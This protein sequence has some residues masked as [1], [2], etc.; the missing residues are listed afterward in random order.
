[1]SQYVYPPDLYPLV[2]DK[3]TQERSNSTVEL[4]KEELFKE[5]VETTYHTSFFTEEKRHLWFRIIFTNK[6]NQTDAEVVA[7]IYQFVF[8][9]KPRPFNVSE[10]MRLSPAT[11]PTHVLIA[12]RE[13]DTHTLEIWGL[14]VSD[15]SWWDFTR[16]ETD[17]GHNPPDGLLISSN[18]AGSISLSRSGEPLISLNQGKIQLGPNI[19]WESPLVDFFIEGRK[20]L[21]REVCNE[22]NRQKFAEDY[23]D[24]YPSNFYLWFLER[25]LNRIREKGHGGTLLIVP[26][27]VTVYDTRLNDR[28]S[29]KYTCSYDAFSPLVRLLV[30]QTNYF[31]AFFSLNKREQI[32]KA[33]FS[34]YDLLQE[35]YKQAEDNVRQAVSFLSS[36]SAVDGAIVM[37]DKLRLIGFGAE[38][39]AT[40]P[41]LTKINMISNYGNMNKHEYRN[42]DLFGTRHRSAFRFC[43]SFED[44]IAAIVSSDGDIRVA[45]RVG[46]DLNLWSNVSVLLYPF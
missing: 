11:D 45:K 44:S 18:R 24:S 33:E 3:W 20:A 12:V 21:Y 15:T 35:E 27:K 39:T 31:T 38:I 5:L 30:K 14:I 26:D 41:S 40:S 32:T 13:S 22:L 34:S 7:G 42:I 29:I 10:L 1:M 8:F 46:S 4:P 23:D 25:L 17:N 2:K 19:L 43:S 28:I 9:E 36:L 6:K 16:H 37:T